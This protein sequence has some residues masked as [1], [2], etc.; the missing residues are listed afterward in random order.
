MHT[1][2]RRGGALAITAAALL[3]VALTACGSDSSGDHSG[4]RGPIMGP[5]HP[6]PL[7]GWSTS[8]R[9]SV[10][11]EPEYLPDDPE[12]TDDPGTPEDA[13]TS[14]DAET[15]DAP[16]PTEESGSTVS[17]HAYRGD[18]SPMGGV[19]IYFR[20]VPESYG[21]LYR[22]S[23]DS[24]GAYSYDLP[25][26]VYIVL[27]STPGDPDESVD[28]TPRQTGPDGVASVSVPPAHTVDFDAP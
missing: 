7:G 9:T 16:E 24:A 22:T 23:T 3:A 28:L 17:G 4:P 13:E 1:T 14:D 19:M 15:P 20:I 26:G 25:G 5:L 10:P 18:G 27:A 21:G 8:P 6:T 11:D 2:G 12:T